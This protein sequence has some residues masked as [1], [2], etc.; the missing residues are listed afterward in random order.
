[1]TACTIV[2]GAAGALGAAVARHLAKTS[3]NPLAL[4]DSAAHRDRLE[5]LARELGTARAYG[6]DLADQAFWD[7]FG[8]R[9]EVE[10]GAPQG[11]AL[12]AGG[13][14]GGAPFWATDDAEWTSMMNGNVLT[15]ARAFRA[16][17][18][19]MVARKDGRIVVIGSRVVERPWTGTNQAAYTASKSAVV[20]LARA[21]A[22][23][24][25]EHGVTINAV[26]PSTLDTPANR[27]AMP[28]A[29]ASRW[30]PLEAAAKQIAFL[31]SDD[32]RDVSGAT[33]PLYGRA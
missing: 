31:L 6:G 5:A 18:P 8:P 20:A 33:I 28:D 22:A 3:G 23:E 26:L 15:V 12:V 30:V 14:R 19:G 10:V 1:M 32:A 16:L 27:A 4:L 2:T 9:V 11:A 13:Y 17:L 24:T 29:D 7:D 25:R 21:V